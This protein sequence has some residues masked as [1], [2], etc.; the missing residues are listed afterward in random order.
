M[1]PRDNPNMPTPLRPRERDSKT[2]EWRQYGFFG[3]EG[4]MADL[5]ISRDAPDALRYC[6]ASGWI[7]ESTRMLTGKTV[8]QHCRDNKKTKC[9]ALLTE[10]RWPGSDADA[11]A[12][13]REVA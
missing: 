1:D 13:P 2:G 11:P 7:D 12:N 6:I 4:A 9:L 10:L 3:Y 5:A 8:A